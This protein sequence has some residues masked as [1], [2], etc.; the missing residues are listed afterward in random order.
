MARRKKTTKTTK[1]SASEATSAAKATQAA[2]STEPAR[3]LPLFYGRPEFLD[4]QRHADHK[5]VGKPDYRFARGANSVPLT[6][7]E[8]ATAAR[9]YPIV[10]TSGDTVGP[11]A[12]LGLRDHTN[13]FV[14]ED[15]EWAAGHYVPAYVRRYPF[16]LV[17]GPEEGQMALGFDADSDL[18]GPEGSQPLF[19][20]EG[21]AE[22]TQRA[23]DLCNAYRRQHE[24]TSRMCAALVELDL[25]VPR[26]ADVQIKDGP[27]LSLDGFQVIDEE[28]LNALPDEE[29]L[30]LRR[31]NWLPLV[32]FQIQSGGNWGTLVART[33]G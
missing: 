17:N 23:L 4:R 30:R 27:K 10:F 7:G 22:A 6:A 18:I 13:L 2:E 25:L 3:R 29:F 8:F 12:V 33:R 9:F 16:I 5:L 26:V 31:E 32:Y 19:E 14:S 1:T 15:G 11:V 24:V 21:P 28:R 20:D